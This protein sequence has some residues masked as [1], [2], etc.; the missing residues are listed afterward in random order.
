M[1]NYNVDI[2]IAIKNT[3]KLT[4]FNKQLDKTAKL[5]AQATQGLKEIG[6]TAKINLASLN[7][8]STALNKAKKEFNDTVLGTKAS[9]LAARDLASAER[10]VNKELKEREALLRKFRFQGGGSAFKSFSQSASQITSPNVLTTAQ[11]KS[12]DRQNRKR[13][14]TAVP[15]G[16]Q[17]FIGPLPMQGPMFGPMQGPNPMMTVDNNP[18]ILKNIAA[19]QLGRSGTG[20]G[21]FSEAI[22]GGGFFP[23]K[24]LDAVTK[25]ID[26]HAKKIAKST[27]K[28]AQLQSQQ[29][30]F[31]NFAD[32]TPKLP[33]PQ[34]RLNFAERLGIGKRANPRGMFASA[35]GAT[36]RGRSALQ[37]GLIGGGFP[38]LF[39]QGGAG[40]IAGGI[41]GLAG[42]ALSPGF[43]FAG[44]IVATAIAQEIE[45]VK[46]FRKAVKQLGEEM[47]SMGVESLFSRKTI[48]ELAREF[49]I[50]KEEAIQLAAGFKT[51]GE[52]FA[53]AQ[54]AAFGENAKAI[55][56]SLSGLRD[57][58]S[59]LGKIN[60]LRDEISET[61]RRD[62][63]QTLATEGSLKA[64]LHLQKALLQKQKQSFIEEKMKNFT[65]IG[66][67]G[68]FGSKRVLTEKELLNIEKQRIERRKELGLV[69][70]E[71]NLQA[72]EDLETQIKINEQLRFI[73]EFQAP[74]DQLREMLNPMRQI[75]DLSVSIRDGFEESFKGIIKGTMTVS[76]AFRNML[77][78][79][80]DHFLDSA[81]R[82][83]ATQI[84]EGFLG[85]FS[86]MFNF[87]F[88]NSI[89]NDVQGFGAPT[90]FAA[91]G[92][93]AGMRKP[94]IVGERG[95]ELFVPNQSG[96]IIPNHDLAG[97][98]GGGTNI[99]VNVDA[100]G[101]SVEGD[102]QR[103]RELGRVI[104]AAVQSELIQQKRPGGLLA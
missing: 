63:L 102:E 22:R 37:S 1:A 66:S 35:G 30:G 41:G 65:P 86:N 79:I 84:Q 36:A 56:D 67:T 64:Q 88:G 6:Q 21:G 33:P 82:M 60:S 72:I 38:L 59:V 10:M 34:K 87:N 91:N 73:S 46:A 17:Q 23:T 93:P 68:A 69:F 50:T 18:R 92:G 98:G 80:A 42:G 62:I 2:S 51:F 14:R 104:S 95:P 45:K 58:E 94:F 78:R 13:G 103:G 29:L 100:S 101:S 57:T 4:A 83:A 24:K 16:P 89:G 20:F 27:A 97:I 48:K 26:R 44:S 32:Q 31:G 9:V 39:G 43:G 54:F 71:N 3:A 47:T 90:K 81:A 40:A 96:N 25:S 5:S 52:D 85:L 53:K 61:Q 7:N 76:E 77:N 12:I 19:S 74:T 70:D 75:L 8:L 55:F 49:E 28:S 99:V 11:Q 15:F